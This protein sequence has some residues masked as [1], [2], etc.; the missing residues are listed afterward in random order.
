WVLVVPVRL[1]GERK[2]TL[3]FYCREPR[4][5]TEGD[6]ETGQTLA[7]LAAAAMGTAELHDTLRTERN[8]FDAA[9]CR[10]PFLADATLILS[11]SL[12]YEKTLAAVTRLAVPEIAD[13]CAVD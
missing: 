3:V 13:W 6:E 12:D 1:G 4:T 9:R 7:N 10:A 11:R 8:A 5:F 2:G